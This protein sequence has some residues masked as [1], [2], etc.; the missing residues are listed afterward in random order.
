MKKMPSFHTMPK[1]AMFSS[2]LMVLMFARARSLCL[3]NCTIFVDPLTECEF[4]RCTGNTSCNFTY[5]NFSDA[6][7]DL[8]TGMLCTGDSVTV[9]LMNGEHFIAQRVHGI[10]ISKDIIIQGQSYTTIRCGNIGDDQNVTSLL[11]FYNS[12]SVELKNL[13]FNTCQRP[14]RFNNIS[15]LMIS[16][17]IFRYDTL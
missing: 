3:N 7:K 1:Y 2:L 6:L 8:D 4:P 15:K 13:E 16:Q 14:I 17:C 5:S 12:T 10:N 11:L 9:Y